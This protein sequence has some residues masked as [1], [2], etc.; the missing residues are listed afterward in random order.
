MNRRQYIQAVG[1]TV[2]LPLTAGQTVARE[3]GEQPP[4]YYTVSVPEIDTQILHISIPNDLLNNSNYLWSVSKSK[5]VA[6]NISREETEDPWG[7]LNLGVQTD[8]LEKVSVSGI[9]AKRWDTLD[10]DRVALLVTGDADHAYLGVTGA[11][12][13]V[14]I[15]GVNQSWDFENVDYERVRVETTDPRDLDTV[16]ILDGEEERIPVFPMTP[17][18]FAQV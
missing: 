4:V 1:A 13:S 8:S 18:Y 15:E 17:S 9:E 7:L 2:A 5:D 16:A 14:H 10:L 11:G 6:L 3:D 12:S